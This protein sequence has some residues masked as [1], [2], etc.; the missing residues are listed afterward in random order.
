M[1]KAQCHFQRADRDC[2]VVVFAAL[3]GVP[4]EDVLRDIPD[5]DLGTV[6]LNGW[7]DW[8]M[9]RGFKV[10]RR[11]GY[12]TDIVPCAHMVS[13]VHPWREL[14]WVYRDEEGD[15][16]DPSH[17]TQAKPA[18]DPFMTELQLYEWKLETISVSR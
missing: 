5:A 9:K 18:D 13:P 7:V 6:T 10:T 11:D 12:W 2:G 1:P 4:Y 8:L 16:H 3:T 17:A 15:V 14:H